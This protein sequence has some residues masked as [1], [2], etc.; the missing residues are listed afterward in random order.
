[1]ISGLEYLFLRIDAF[2]VLALGAFAITATML[3]ARFGRKTDK[4]ELVLSF[5]LPLTFPFWCGFA[6]A[7]S[8]SMVISPFIAC[9]LGAGFAL[10][11]LRRSQA[12]RVRMIAAGSLPMNLT[13]CFFPTT[14]A[15]TT[16]YF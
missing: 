16:R 14:I 5:G 6:Y 12:K 10:S 9:A 1:V 4:A 15:W 11:A 13:L 2:L 8:V 3:A 7:D